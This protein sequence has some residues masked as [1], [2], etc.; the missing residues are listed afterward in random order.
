MLVSWGDLAAAFMLQ[1]KDQWMV[2][3][4]LQDL[5]HVAEGVGTD[6]S[7][8]A[9]V[10]ADDS[11]ATW[12]LP[13]QACLDEACPAPLAIAWPCKQPRDRL[14]AAGATHLGR[15]TMTCQEA[16]HGA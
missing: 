4:A 5:C 16:C 15:L 3:A 10:F 7:R 12:K 8:R 13:I 2:T 11:G 9:A 14:M 6:A 1:G